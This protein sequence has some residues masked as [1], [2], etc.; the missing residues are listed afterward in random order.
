MTQ[1]QP[2]ANEIPAE[3]PAT[4]PEA[5]PAAEPQAATGAT[6]QPSGQPAGGP[7]PREQELEAEVA[8][9]KDQLLR[10][11]AETENVRRRLEQQAEDRAKYAVGNF[12]KDILQVA[13]NLRRALDTIPAEARTA[14]PVAQKLVEGVELT[15]RTFLST[16]ER[17][18]IKKIVSLGQRFDPHF[19]QAMME[20]E[21]VTATSGTVVLEVQAGYTIHDR[22]LREAMV[23]VSKG[24][25][26]APPAVDE[27]V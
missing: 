23:G 27:T 21:D 18:G 10:A 12:A 22:L 20:I 14:D 19:H 9:L 2:H 5:A 24:G 26:K 16:L 11:V 3:T 25:P 8:K 7:S 6:Q 15:E 1:D 17:Y 13:D 4:T